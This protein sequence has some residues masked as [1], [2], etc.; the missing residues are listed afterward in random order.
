[1][2]TLAKPIEVLTATDLLGNMSPLRFKA[3]TLNNEVIVI[4][5]DK[6]ESSEL[7][8]FSGNIMML[9]KCR[10]IVNDKSRAFELKFEFKS[11]KWMLW[12]M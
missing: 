5:V 1:M 12:R 6:V 4:K 8:K 10:G 7:E 9:Y 3:K 2:R 11:C